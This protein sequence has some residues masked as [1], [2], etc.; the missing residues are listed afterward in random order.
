MQCVHGG[1]VQLRL[2][3]LLASVVRSH[4]KRGCLLPPKCWC[5][6]HIAAKHILLL[7]F[8]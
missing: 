3:F 1:Y 8:M 4:S 5:L 7:A 2:R 6:V